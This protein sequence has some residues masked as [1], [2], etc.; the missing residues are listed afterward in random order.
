MKC[1]V[2]L[3][4]FLQASFLYISSTN[5]YLALLIHFTIFKFVMQNS[6]YFLHKSAERQKRKTHRIHLGLTIIQETLK[7]KISHQKFID[8]RGLGL[9]LNEKKNKHSKLIQLFST[10]PVIKPIINKIQLNITEYSQI[11]P[12]KKLLTASPSVYHKSNRKQLGHESASIKKQLN[13]TSL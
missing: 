10:Q 9:G 7:V 5:T 2:E 11:H 12:S 8:S 6:T 13:L 4:N 1:D 3:E